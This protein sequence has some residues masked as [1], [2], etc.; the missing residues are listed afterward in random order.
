MNFD[1]SGPELAD[2]VAAADDLARRVSGLDHDP[3][4]N[5]VL[6]DLR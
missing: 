1:L 2:G 5:R 3:A 6:R 4:R